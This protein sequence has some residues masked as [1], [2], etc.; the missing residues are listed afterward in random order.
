MSKKKY[1]K[2]VL[3]EEQITNEQIMLITEKILKYLKIEAPAQRKHQLINKGIDAGLVVIILLGKVNH[4][5][6]CC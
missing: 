3:T 1:D 5:K 6:V 4:R 2:K